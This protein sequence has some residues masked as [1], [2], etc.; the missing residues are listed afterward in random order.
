MKTVLHLYHFDTSKGDELAAYGALRAKLTAQGL[1]CFNSWTPGKREY[2]ESLRALDGKEA[3]LE[4]ATLF[5]N[6]WNTVPIEGTGLPG[7]RVFDW[8][9]SIFDNRSIKYG[10][11]L[12]QTDAMRL[13]RELRHACGYCGFQTDTPDTFCDRC[14]DSEYLKEDELQLLRMLPV[15][16]TSRVTRPALSESELAGLKARYTYA[17]VHGTTERGKARIAKMRQKLEKEYNR[18]IEVATAERDGMLW[19]MDRGVNTGNVIYY[20]HTGRFC[21][22]Y[23]AGLSSDARKALE[24]AIEGFPFPYDVEAVK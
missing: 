6:Q 12:E 19:L 17:Q 9:E 2:S 15:N 10:H 21:F 5:D 7:L 4:T 23:R 16:V 18:A 22:G 3:E 24:T 13:T 11:Y 8:A 20:K 14:L 1:S